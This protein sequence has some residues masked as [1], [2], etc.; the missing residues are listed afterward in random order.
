MPK[1]IFFALLDVCAIFPAGV[2]D[3]SAKLSRNQKKT[4]RKAIKKAEMKRAEEAAK[5]L[6]DCPVEKDIAGD[7]E[8]KTLYLLPDQKVPPDC[9]SMLKPEFEM[10]V[11]G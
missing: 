1:H 3:G 2:M 6:V 4:K 7:E 8:E 5:G 11:S 10:D 9:V